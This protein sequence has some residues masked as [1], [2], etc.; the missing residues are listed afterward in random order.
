M[1]EEKKQP[2]IREYRYKFTKALVDGT[3]KEYEQVIKRKLKTNKI[4]PGRATAHN[5]KELRA[6]LKLFDDDE[7]KAIINFCKEE[8]L[9]KFKL[10]AAENS[11]EEEDVRDTDV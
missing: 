3:V 8:C 6:I 11:D 2:I 4:K 1:A 5:R 10:P 9:G 7:C